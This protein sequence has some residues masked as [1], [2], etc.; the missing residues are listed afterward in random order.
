LELEFV[1]FGE[2]LE[3]AEVYLGFDEVV[4]FG[5]QVAVEDGEEVY[6]LLQVL[7]GLFQLVNFQ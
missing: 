3:L 2:I 4:E 5:L 1:V 6:F 7:N